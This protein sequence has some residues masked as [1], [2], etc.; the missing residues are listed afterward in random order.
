MTTQAKLADCNAIPKPGWVSSSHRLTNATERTQ[1]HRL[2]ETT[3]CGGTYKRSCSNSLNLE[4]PARRVDNLAD[5][6]LVRSDNDVVASTYSS[7]HDR[8][9]HDIIKAGSSSE[10]SD[11]ACLIGAHRF[12]IAASEHAYQA[13]LSG[14]TP[15]SFGED[16]CRNDRDHLLSDKSDV[17][18]PHPP[19]IAIT[20]DEG[21]SI[22]GDAGHY[23][24]R[25]DRRVRPRRCRARASPSA[26][27]SSVSGPCSRSQAATPRRPA[28]RRRR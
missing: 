2:H 21:A 8:H 3:G 6:A 13:C 27:S 28:S 18:R 12:E 11:S 10:F 26:N 23:A 16:R 17:E 5:V 22:I 14:P 9:V 4:P 1:A 25:L 24:D 7:F 19:I 20:R 15:P